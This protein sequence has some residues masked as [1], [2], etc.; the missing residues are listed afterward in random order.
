MSQFNQFNQI[1]NSDKSL[2]E[3]FKEVQD[4][5]YGR[6]KPKEI[7]DPRENV[8]FNRI[9]VIDK[10]F[11]VFGAIIGILFIIMFFTLV[12]SNSIFATFEE[13]KVAIA[14]FEQNQYPI[15]LMEI[16]SRNISSSTTKEIVT[17]EHEIPYETT[18][19]ENSQLPLDETKVVQEGKV[20]YLDQ[21][22]IRTFEN[23][24]LVNENVI[25]ENV[26]T[27]PVSEVIEVGT[28]QFL[29]DI[30]AHIG[31]TLYTKD[32]AILYSE[33]EEN[34]EKT[35]CMIY[36]FIDIKILSE[37]SGW[38]RV[39]VDEYEGYVKNDLITSSVVYPEVVELCRK[40]R[41]L[42]SVNSAM[43]V[44]KPSGLSKDDFIRVLSNHRED[45][46][47]I[48]QECA[49]FFYEAEQ[50]YKINGLFLASI[51]IHES[52]WG[53]SN[54]SKQKKNLFG[55]GSYDSAPLESSYAFESYKYG[56]DLVA[57]VLVKY[58]L[59]EPGTAI[60]DGEV[61]TGNY[62]NG[63]TIAGVNVRY[64]SDT[65]WSNRVYSIM[66]SLYKEL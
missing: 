60:Y 46:D 28:S 47:H 21:T 58:Y 12:N 20:G 54:I 45:K 4:I 23:E 11:N 50:N 48:I 16:L 5:R 65:N 52:N 19:V 26:K 56:I 31:D 2:T 1:N 61:A 13:E 30:K 63:P 17:E 27:E 66:E 15:E 7:K 41:I 37:K 42:V 29:F 49:E 25:S 51:G 9:Y 36:P 44:N 6:A 14:R 8:K 33:P 3:L 62:Y 18:H 22:V 34:E 32:T 35:I 64:A 57:K 39:S 40:Q 43:Y 55:Y 53:T 38:S 24:E 59:N 10:K